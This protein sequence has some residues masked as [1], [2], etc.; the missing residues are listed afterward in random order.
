MMSAGSGTSWPTIAAVAVSIK[1]LPSTLD[2]NGNERDAR[3]LHS[4]TL[5]SAGA[6]GPAA[7]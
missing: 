1:F 7:G 2:T 5:N 6:S 3:R 4:I